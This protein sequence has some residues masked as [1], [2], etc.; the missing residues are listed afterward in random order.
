[1]NDYKVIL[2]K[3]TGEIKKVPAGESVIETPQSPLTDAQLSRL[4]AMTHAELLSA[5][6][7][8]AQMTGLVLPMSKAERITLAINRLT[9]KVADPL[10]PVAALITACEKLLERMEGKATQKVETL[11]H[12]H[13][14]WNFTVRFVAADGKGL[15]VIENGGIKNQDA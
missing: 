9:Q 3:E 12:E 7:E 5:C 4:D 13:K 14:D 10:T 11:S 6:K 2:N 15:P 1:M 8:Y